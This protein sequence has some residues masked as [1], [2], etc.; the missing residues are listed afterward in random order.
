MPYIAP[1]NRMP[2]E[3][4]ETLQG[5]ADK[6]YIKML[7]AWCSEIGSFDADEGGHF[8]GQG[9]IH[10]A[11]TFAMVPPPGEGVKCEM[12]PPYEFKIPMRDR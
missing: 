6:G 7:T 8:H 11:E 3:V 5:L 4:Y 10:L 12:P 9:A 2:M 1:G